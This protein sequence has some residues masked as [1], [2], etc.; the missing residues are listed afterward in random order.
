M[1]SL[2]SFL[3]TGWIIWLNYGFGDCYSARWGKAFLLA[4]PAA[5]VVVLIIAPTVLQLSR[6]LVARTRIDSATPQ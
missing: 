3:M 6:Y 5:F 1:S 2:M 4:W